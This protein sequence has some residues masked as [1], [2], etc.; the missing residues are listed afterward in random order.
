MNREHWVSVLLN[1]NA[2]DDEIYLLLE[3]SF[4]LTS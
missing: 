3:Q 1:G 4:D 2:S